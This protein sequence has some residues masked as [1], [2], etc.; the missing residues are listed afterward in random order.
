MSGLQSTNPATSSNDT[1]SIRVRP[2]LAMLLG[3]LSLIAT[4]GLWWIGYAAGFAT[5]P[6]FD[7]TDIVIRRSPGELAVW[8]IANLQFDAQR[9]AL[10]GGIVAWLVLGA[11]LALGLRQRPT[12]LTGATIGVTTALL[13]TILAYVS[14]NVSGVGFGIWLL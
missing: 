5:F 13:A 1:D 7:L 11:V 14:N 4:L 12:A 9:L 3:L 8:A 6:P 2:A 10:L